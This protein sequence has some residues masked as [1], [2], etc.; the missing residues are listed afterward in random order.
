[1]AVTAAKVRDELRRGDLTPA[2]RRSWPH[3]S[4]MSFGYTVHDTGSGA[5]E[6]WCHMGG[7]DDE[8][9][10]KAKRL[11]NRVR[12]HLALNGY[13]TYTDP[14]RNPHQVLV[15]KSAELTLDSK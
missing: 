10:E 2:N 14:E 13:S 5:V 3:P 8:A 11:A 12:Q 9:F 6:V 1:M 4:Q 15:L 7:F